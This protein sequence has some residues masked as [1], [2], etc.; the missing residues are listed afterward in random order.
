M[1]ADKGYSTGPAPA[2][3]DVDKTHKTEKALLP[4]TVLSGFLGAG[5]TTL[6]QHVLHNQEGL[7]VAVIVN[8]MAEVNIDAMLVNSDQ[9]LTVQDKM[10]EMQNGCICCT[11]R[12]DLIQHVT[13][14]AEEK[15]FDYLLIESTGISEPMPV[16]ATFVTEVEGKAMLGQVARLDTLVTVVDGKNFFETYGTTERLVDRPVLGAE[17]GDQ[18]SIGTLLADQVECANVIVINKV[19]LLKE[20]EILGLEAVLKKM[21]PKAEL[22]RS[23]YGKIDLKLALNTHKFDFAEVQKMPGWLQ[24]LAGG[25]TPETEEYNISSL[26]FRSDKPFHPERLEQLMFEG[27]DDLLRSKGLLWVAGRDHA[28]LVWGQA[29]GA[30]TL[31]AGAWAH[32][33]VPPEQWPPHLEKYKTRPYGDKRTE[34]VFI[35]R[36]LDKAALRT[37]LENALL[38]DEEFQLGPKGWEKFIKD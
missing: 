8:D 18:R 35:S 6:L 26:V 14:L 10:V 31:E 4:V 30:V 22:V 32:G 12:D 27:F 37:R 20:E 1:G 9:V 15:R 16:A 23:S 33:S 38:T 25:H 13:Q 3:M 24:E 29:G 5:K 28:A 17:E 34:L 2:A 7:R 11:L 36:D 19:D 21:N